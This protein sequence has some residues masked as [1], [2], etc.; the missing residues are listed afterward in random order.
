M[1][2]R[3]I[4]L[5]WNE[6]MKEKKIIEIKDVNF[7]YHDQNNHIK[8]LENINIDIR[9]NEIVGILGRSGAGKSSLLRI[10]AG[11]LKPSSG[12]ILYYGHEL[13]YTEHKMAMVFQNIGLVPWLNVYENVSLGL[14]AK[15]LPK[16]IHEDEVNDAIDIVG[17]GGYEQSYPKEISNG[18]RQRVG[19]A[20]ALAID[21]EVLLLDSPFSSLDYI[22]KDALQA[23]LLDLWFKRYSI[24]LETILLVTH[25]I[26]ETVSLCDR[27]LIMSSN[28][29][30]IVEEI[31]INLPHP[32]DP[33]SKEFQSLVSKIYLAMTKD[34]SSVNSVNNS[35]Q[36]NYPQTI[37]VKSLIHFLV[38]IR[39]EEVENNDT[40][41]AKITEDL[42]L[43]SDQILILTECLVLLKF[44][45][46]A[47][48]KISLTASGQIVIEADDE[49][50]KV[51]F[52]EHLVR[53][54]K[55]VSDLYSK[56]RKAK[57]GGISKDVVLK[58]LEKTFTK[59]EAKKI[60]EAT[61]SW[62]I[63]A[64]LFIYDHKLERLVVVEK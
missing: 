42:H 18:M 7:E 56:L 59:R 31:R 22:T 46:V 20:R 6:A 47:G 35:K 62:A 55:F 49:A 30:R 24:P 26:E 23:D 9:E 52:R 44:I 43:S 14:E 5:D 64:D 11:L 54:V 12:N 51:I 61:I 41:I 25:N 40:T 53:N 10:V 13:E 58:T 38:T 2:T 33:H 19:L 27:V 63:Y 48:D 45:K 16:H 39:G 34:T 8:I 3:L 4:S 21:P 29:G 60:I 28:P 50:K 32:R 36:K 37:S 57:M 17:L 1:I 15:K